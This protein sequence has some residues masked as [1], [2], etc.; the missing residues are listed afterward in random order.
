[1]NLLALLAGL[2]LPL[3]AAASLAWLASTSVLAL[4]AQLTL[5]AALAALRP[6]GGGM[7]ME[8]TTRVRFLAWSWTFDRQ[9][10]AREGWWG[11]LWLTAAVIGGFCLP[12]LGVAPLWWLLG[13]HL[14]VSEETA[15]I[16]AVALLLG[17]SL[18]QHRR[19]LPLWRWRE[20]LEHPGR[21]ADEEVAHWVALLRTRRQADGAIGHVGG[22][23]TAEVGLHELLDAEAI[24][25]EA[26]GRGVPGAAELRAP[27]LAHLAAREEGGGFPVYPGGLPREALGAR[28]REAL[29]A[30]R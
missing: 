5:A 12:L 27:L 14:P 26:Q 25:R 7:V 29:A 15:V 16:L 18:P 1:M 9:R 30:V 21:V 19:E 20:A 4:V 24:L 11:T 22:I 13:P 6:P 2:I 23:G 17:L 28:A 10:S 8:G 3:A